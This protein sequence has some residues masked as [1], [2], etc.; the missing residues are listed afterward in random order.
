MTT[1]PSTN[2]PS[3]CQACAGPG[4]RDHQGHQ[5]CAGCIALLDPTLPAGPQ[6]R[7]IQVTLIKAATQILQ[8]PHANN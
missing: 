4:A 2:D 1:D 6:I 3:C 7:A 8:N 5:L